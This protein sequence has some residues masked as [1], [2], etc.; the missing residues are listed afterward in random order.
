MGKMPE[1]LKRFESVRQFILAS[2]STVTA[3]LTDNPTR[4]YIENVPKEI[5]L[6]FQKCLQN[7][8]D[9]FQWVIWMIQCF[10]AIL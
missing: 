1:C 5:I 3:K 9:M 2:K 8:D 6:L 7:G 10:A 4:F